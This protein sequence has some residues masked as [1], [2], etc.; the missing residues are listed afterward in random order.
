[1][2][3]RVT[4]D[5]EA[6]FH[7]NASQGIDRVQKK[8]DK[9]GNTDATAKVDADDRASSKLSKVI[10]AA[11][12]FGGSTY[13]AKINALDKASSVLRKIGDTA[14]S[15][16][17][18]PIEIPLR[19]VGNAMSVLSGITSKIFNLKNL[20]MGIVAG[21]AVKKITSEVISQPISLADSYTGAKIG[22]STLLG[23]AEGQAMMDKLD[24][25][26][27]ATPFKTSG[28][29]DNA[30][31]MLAMGWDAENIIEDMRTIGDAAAATGKMDQGLESIV[32]ALSQIKTKGK[33]STEELNQ[34]SEAGIAAKAMLAE[35][36]G[37]GTG[38]SGIAQM[39]ADLEDGLIGSEV[40][41]QA[42]LLGM[43][44]FEGTMERTANETVEG[45][46]SQIEDAFE[47]NIFRRW[48]QGLQD[49]A[50]RGFGEIVELL[51]SS[52]EALAKFG[53]MVYE[54]GVQFSNWG[55]DKL[56][57]VIK[58]IKG[59]TESYQFANA[60]LGEKISL[61]WNGVIVNPLKE[62]WEN[63][64]QE[65]TATTA[66]EIGNWIGTTLSKGILAILGMTDILGESGIDDTKGMSVA[67]SFA[68]G[69]VD[70]FDVSAITDKIV[71]AIGNVWNALPA[72][73]K[74]L[75]VG[76]AGGKAIS[77]IGNVVGGIA[78]IAG[79]IGKFAGGAKLFMGSTGNAMVGGSGVLGNMANI[80]Y[81]LT[82]GAA[83]SSLGGGTASLIGGGAATGAVAAGASL[84]HVGTSAYKAYEAYK[85]GDK[86]EYSANVNEAA[87]TGIGVASGAA[88][89]AAIGSVIPVIGTAAGALIGAGIGGIA[90]WWNGKKVAE[91]I[92]ANAAEVEAAKYGTERMKKAILDT[93]MSAE[94]LAKEFELA[95]GETM[96]HRFG[97]IELSLAEI[98]KLSKDIVYNDMSESMEKFAKAT[99]QANKSLETFQS[100]ASD[101]ERLNFDMEE[102]RWKMEL[103][104]ET[105]LTDEEITNVKAQVQSYIESAEKVLSDQHYKFNAAVEVLLQPEQGK[106]YNTYSSIIKG[107]N[108]LYASLQKE[109]D[110]YTSNLTSTYDLALQD[111]VIT[112]DEQDAISKIQTQIRLITEKISNAET[113]ASFYVQKLDFTMGD[114]SFESYENFKA[115]LQ[116]QLETYIATQKEALTIGITGLNLELEEGSISKEEY[117]TQVQ[118]LMDGYE[119]NI[120]TMTARV[121]AVRLEGITE[122]FDDVATVEEITNTINA[123]FADGQNPADITFSD[124][125]AHL[126]ID[127]GALTEETKAT[128]L[129]AIQDE[130]A[131]MATGENALNAA[132]DI[133][134]S[135]ESVDTTGVYSG[136]NAILANSLSGENALTATGDVNTTLAPYAS[137][138]SLFENE[139]SSMR[140]DIGTAI[141]SSLSLPF[142]AGAKAQVT[143][144]WSITNPFANISVNTNGTSAT[145]SIAADNNANGGFIGSKVL[146]WLGEEGYPE[147]VIPFAPHRRQRALKLYEQTGKMLG[148]SEHANGGMV[149]DGS[150]PT[151]STGGGSNGNVEVNVGNITISVNSSGGNLAE[152][153]DS[154]KEEIAEKISEVLYKA[155][156]SQFSNTPVRA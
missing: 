85:A 44:Q 65:K 15:L 120:S 138:G 29:I 46:K 146:S 12:K 69:F 22:F 119:S 40:A 110:S 93:E 74:T 61:L 133:K 79:A 43:K 1:M 35:Q 55:A 127:E 52:E 132:L 90:G 41:I 113:E 78:N 94:E 51:D 80:G 2:A 153:L 100:A 89:G 26:A 77:G 115:G 27:K 86:T 96:Q 39:S 53:D 13:E 137:D 75:I 108:S 68:K 50:K 99:E 116:S 122:A 17:R 109:L 145:A 135:V 67:Q 124:I 31:K 102:R 49:G 118:Y 32:R 103:G 62:W 107:G 148:I 37:Y 105:K 38:D 111:G 106:E 66:G 129:A 14:S 134:T 3:N 7:D 141:E 140:G 156:S 155:F 42:L 76:Y 92:R 70:G 47:I 20:I 154:Q 72:W 87:H 60:S 10:G 82:G 36:L 73:A 81:A 117:D 54:I 24:D 97:N 6:K 5:V 126:N 128:F 4:I 101:M 130:V 11:S 114:L 143:L 136:V 19:I 104:L 150:V 139:T 125:N 91:N 144:D 63:G 9:L 88:F 121:G 57:G 151:I 28:V 45:L 48:G 152:N 112:I 59:I 98:S 33:L 34:L 84:V 25:F 147:M 30:N 83:T 71:D 149:G 56:E 131:A 142:T 18:K 64:G 123:L 95:C 58:N 23:D 8:A 21:A 16:A